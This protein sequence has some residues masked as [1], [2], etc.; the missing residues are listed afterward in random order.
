M[1]TKTFLLIVLFSIGISTSSFAQNQGATLTQTIEWIKSYLAANGVQ[2]IIKGSDG[3]YYLGLESITFDSSTKILF[4]KG[5]PYQGMYS[6]V[7]I[8]LSKCT[9]IKKGYLSSASSDFAKFRITDDEGYKSKNDFESTAILFELT[10]NGDY[11][12]LDK[13]FKHLCELCGAKLMNEDLF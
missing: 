3:K 12:K 1:K 11:T 13:A 8:D 7:S 10:E 5:K 6:L 9:S 4:I 2:L